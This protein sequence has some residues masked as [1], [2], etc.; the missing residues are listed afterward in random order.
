LALVA[1]PDIQR[2]AQK[3]ID[4]IVGFERVPTVEDFENLPYIQAIVKETHRFR[5][6]APLAI[7]HASLA[8]EIF[9]GYLIPQGT[10]IFVNN[11]GMFHD[12]AVFDEPEIFNPDRFLT[13][14]YGTRPHVDESGRRHDMA[15]GSG[16]RICPGIRLAQN[17]IAL[18]TMNLL[19]A[20]NFNE[21]INPDTKLPIKVDIHDYAKGILTC[22]NPFKC[23]IQ[24]RSADHAQLIK[25]EFVQARSTF[26][27]FEH[28]L[29]PEDAAHVATF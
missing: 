11:W 29:L 3:E 21:A 10:T 7:P 12:E 23:D 1:F 9:D 13:S 18:N 24:V 16:R 14:E 6:V 2:K 15:F 27:S 22:L 5:P 20:F 28:D 25:S 19:W 8:D 17:S 26:R 4:E